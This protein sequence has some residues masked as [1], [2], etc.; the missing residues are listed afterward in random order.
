[1]IK[2]SLST[3]KLRI[4]IFIYIIGFLFL[5]L[6]IRLTNLQLFH[7]YT[8]KRLARKNIIKIITLPQ[9]RGEFVDRK[10]VLLVSNIPDYSLVIYPYLLIDREKTLVF[11]ERISGISYKE[12]EKKLKGAKSFYKPVIIKK[13]LL[14]D[15]I[16]RIDENITDLPGISVERKPLRYYKYGEATSHIIGYTGE[17]TEQEL[18]RERELKEGDIIGKSGLEKQ[19]DKYLRGQPGVMYVEVDARGREVGIFQQIRSVKPKP[20]ARIELTIDVGIQQLADSLLSKYESGSVVA[21]NP[22]DGSVIALYSKPG[23]DP[24]K[25]VRGIS[26][27]ALKNMISTE[28][29]SFW[30]RATMSAYAPGS[31]FKII[32]A[33]I[34]LDYGVIDSN[35]VMNKPCLGSLRIG[36]RIFHCWKRH[37]SLN[38]HEA[39]VQSCDVFF[40]QLGLKVNFKRLLKGMQKLSLFGKTGIDLPEEGRGLFPDENWF[41]K[42]FKIKEPTKGMIANLSIGQGEVLLTPLEVCS[43]FAG[44][45]NYGSIATPHLVKDI[46]NVSGNTIYKYEPKIRKIPLSKKTITFLRNAMLGV[47]NE[48]KGT[49]VF[50]KIRDIKVAGKTG[51]A[52]NPMGKEHAWFVAFAPFE[53]PEICVVVMIENA[54]HGGGVAAPIAKA[55]IEKA[56]INGQE[57][58]QEQIK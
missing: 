52:E 16:A 45:A 7:S 30:N 18:K 24:N 34:A 57:K 46:K 26:L 27:K 8:Y 2:S 12:I 56:L 49:G 13:H 29:S 41:M 20:G 1:M 33:A 9:N 10:G 50:A 32:V 43:F 14:P 40:Y 31:I 15:E 35:A 55:I 11:L 39:I 28:S 48:R 5:V 47:V 36:N 23:F 3:Y 21:I 19:Y 38:L 6:V 25:L 51:T 53:E 42:R 44:L 54:G 17:V 4:N 58:K 22:Q 37:G